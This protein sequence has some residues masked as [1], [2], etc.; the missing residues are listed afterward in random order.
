MKAMTVNFLPSANI[1]IFFN[2]PPLSC[3][4]FH[5]EKVTFLYGT[6]AQ[7]WDFHFAERKGKTSLRGDIL[8]PYL[9]IEMEKP[10]V[11]L[12]VNSENPSVL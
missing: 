2:L 11:D 10:N 8:T 1:Y 3:V 12:G 4:T 9:R 7:G 5:Y 6:D